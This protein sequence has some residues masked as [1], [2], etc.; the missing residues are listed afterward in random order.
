M[1]G[2]AGFVLAVVVSSGSSAILLQQEDAEFRKLESVWNGA[3]LRADADALERLWHDD[4]QVAVP[5]MALMSK[6]EALNVLRS[7]RMMFERYESSDLKVRTYGASAVVTGRLQRSRTF[8]G[9]KVEDDWQFTKVYVRDSGD[10]RVVAFHASEA[11]V[12]R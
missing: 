12:R 7:S 9:R 5:Q 10:W 6:A 4:L 3:H 11:A 2:M 1:R 8:G